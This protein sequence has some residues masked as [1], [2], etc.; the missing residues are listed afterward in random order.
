MGIASCPVQAEEAPRGLR[1]GVIIPLSGD[2]ASIGDAF[3]N[4]MQVALESLYPEHRNLLHMS[5]EDDALNAAK[6]V[7]AAHKLISEQHVDVLVNISSG[8]A[9]AI[10]PIAESRK[11]PLI[12]IAS[13][14]KVVQGRRYAFNFWVTPDE[15]AR[16]MLPEVLRRGYKKVA[17]ITTTHEGAFAVRGAFDAINK[18]QVEIVL[19]EDY[20]P[21]ARDFKTYLSKIRNAKNIDAIHPILFPGQLS[22][23]AKQARSMGITLPLF[24]WEFFEDKNEVK[25]SD[26]TLIGS[27]YVNA[28]DATT[29]FTKAFER[30]FPSSSFYTAPNGHDVVMLLA[31]AVQAGPGGGEGVRDYLSTL[32]DFRGALGTYSA[33]GDNRFTLKAAV[34]LVT[35]D[36]F[37]KL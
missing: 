3:K 28:D 16:A 13:D 10:A 15:E 33:S 34:K 1:V 9:H 35:K 29:T 6:A 24:G 32:K 31:A 5:Y 36:G 22:T 4:G 30:R 18:G 11:I 14:P 37:Q 12:A 7:T 17:R 27:W 20:P 2:A 25:S 19:D 26:G 8:T 23:F 21:E